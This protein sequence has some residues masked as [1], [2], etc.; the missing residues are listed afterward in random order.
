MNISRVLLHGALPLLFLLPLLASVTSCKRQAPPAKVSSPFTAQVVFDD[1]IH[2]FG[3]FSSDSAMQRHVFSFVNSSD[4]PAVILNADLSCQCTSVK[5]TQEA[6]HP[7]QSGKV[8][9]TF[10]G[11]KSAPGYFDKSV[12]IRMNASHTYLLRI[13]GCMK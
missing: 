2:D 1:S 5:Y 8:E 3:T 13:K 4:I 9:V 6:I 12:R 11:T 7:G 10:D